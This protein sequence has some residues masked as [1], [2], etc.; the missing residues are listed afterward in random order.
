M[1]GSLRLVMLDTV[2]EQVDLWG[3]LCPLP[4]LIRCQPV[5]ARVAS[6]SKLT[7]GG[8]DWRGHF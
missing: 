1:R 6:T 8:L 4:P 3:A 7:K 5:H 2:L